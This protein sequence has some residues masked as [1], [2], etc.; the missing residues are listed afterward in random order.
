[1]F[2]WTFCGAKLFHVEQFE[3]PSVKLACKRFLRISAT[4]ALICAKI[5]TLFTTNCLIIA[6][7][8]HIL[9]LT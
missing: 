6:A 5:W 9:P 8:D 7:L 3:E 2:P 1:M 4:L